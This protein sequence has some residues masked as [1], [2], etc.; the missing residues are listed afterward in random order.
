[1]KRSIETLYTQE[2]LSAYAQ[3]DFIDTLTVIFWIVINAKSSCQKLMSSILLNNYL[4]KPKSGRCGESIHLDKMSDDGL[5]LSVNESPVA[6]ARPLVA[7][8]LEARKLGSDY[9]N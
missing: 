6:G 5:D 1:M 9:H 3:I 7:A 8:V 4:L 2:L